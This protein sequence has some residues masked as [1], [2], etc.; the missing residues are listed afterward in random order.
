MVV[1]RAAA[2]QCDD[3]DRVRR[4]QPGTGAHDEHGARNECAEEQGASADRELMVGPEQDEDNERASG[5]DEAIG[6][7]ATHPNVE[8]HRRHEGSEEECAFRSRGRDGNEWLNCEIEHRPT[9]GIG[10][11]RSRRSALKIPW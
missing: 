11:S 4:S 1:Q 6:D 8:G 7:S 3:R 9:V 2:D 10:A 5:G